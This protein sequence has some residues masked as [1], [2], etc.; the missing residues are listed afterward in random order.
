MTKIKENNRNLGW[1]SVVR[2][3]IDKTLCFLRQDNNAVLGMTTAYRLKEE[4]VLK[5]R[6]RLRVTLINAHVIRPI[7][8]NDTRRTLYIPQAID[9]YN[10]YMGGVD[11]A[12]QL[13]K[14]FSVHRNFE[15]RN[16]HPLW[17]WLFDICLVNGYV[18]FK[19]QVEDQDHNLHRQFQEELC[20]DLLEWP[21]EGE[22]PNQ[23]ATTHSWGQFQHHGGYWEFCSKPNCK[24]KRIPLAEYPNEAVPL[25]KQARHRV[26][27]GCLACKAYL[28]QKG[29]CFDAYHGQN[30]V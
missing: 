15:R 7:F 22:L 28:C 14:P 8:G 11:T 30:I 20:Q 10:H 12:N 2:E 27:G 24:R 5:E 3:Q 17:Y 4:T 13:R 18:I 19:H 23:A 29:S 26:N 1:D 21:Y 25:P 9:G 6:R 16:W